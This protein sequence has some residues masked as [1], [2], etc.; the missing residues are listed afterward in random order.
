MH[1]QGLGGVEMQWMTP[2]E[3]EGKFDFLSERWAQL[4][5]FTVQKAKELGMRVDFTLGTGWPYGALDSHRTRLP[6]P[7]VDKRGRAGAEWLRGKDTWGT[8]RARETYRVI[9]RANAGVRRGAGSQ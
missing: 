7:P 6:V 1:K 4:V 2:L 3:L 8:W 9:C 5:K